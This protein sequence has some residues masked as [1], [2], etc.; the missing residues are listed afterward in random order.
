MN[1]RSIADLNRVVATSLHL[2]PTDIDVVVGVPRSGMLP[3]TLLALYLHLP[4]TDV[5]GLIEDAF[6]KADRD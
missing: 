6:F 2:V 4:L 5:E 1:Y 3:A